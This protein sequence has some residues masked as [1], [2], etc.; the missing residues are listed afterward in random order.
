MH[1]FNISTQEFEVT[2]VYRHNSGKTRATQRKPDKKKRN[3]QK[4]NWNWLLSL[5]SLE[6]VTHEIQCKLQVVWCLANHRRSKKTT[7][8]ADRNAT[9]VLVT[10]SVRTASRG[11]A[12]E[13][14][15]AKEAEK[16]KLRLYLCI[17][18]LHISG[19]LLYKLDFYH[20]SNGK[21]R[22]YFKRV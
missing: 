11:V 18:M 8:K 4:R 12:R 19:Y 9:N 3:K 17:L 15:R 1:T 10:L 21:H 13:R 16:N 20:K 2:L 14:G 7:F 22:S 6:T 5:G